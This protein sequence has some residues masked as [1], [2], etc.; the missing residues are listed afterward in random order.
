MS[1]AGTCEILLSFI[2]VREMI[3]SSVVSRKVARSW[4]DN[5][6][7]GMHLPQPVMAA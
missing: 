1:I 5:T 2:P 3:Q 6:A 7:G 4:F